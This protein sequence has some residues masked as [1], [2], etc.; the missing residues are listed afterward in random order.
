MGKQSEQIPF[1]PR[2]EPRI[3]KP[4]SLHNLR[5]VFSD[6]VDFIEAPL[7]IG[8]DPNKKAVMLYILGMVRNERANDYILRPLSQNETLHSLPLDEAIFSM[9]KG[10]LYNMS[11]Q[12]RTSTDEVVFDLINGA[13]IL[14]FPER[15]DMLSCMVPTEEKRSV[16]PSNN[17]PALKGSRDSFVES[18]RTNTSLVRRRLRTP[19]LRIKEQ[20]VGRQTI[21]PVDILYIDGLTNPALVRETEKRLKKIDIDALLQSAS[22]EE[23]MCDTVKTPFPLMA[24]T[25][26]PDRF[27]TGLVEG[28]VGILADGLPFG[29]L[30]PGTLGY[31]FKANEDRSKNWL[32][33]SFMRV[34]RYCCMLLALFLPALYV[35]AVNFHPEMLPAAL[36]WSIVEAKL[37]VPFS[38]VFEVLLLLLSFEVVQEAGLRLPPAIGTTVSIL[39]G[40]VVGSAAVEAQIVSPAVLIVVAASGIAG[41]T[42]PSQEF[43][44]A[45][46]LWRVAL[47]IAAAL[48]GL[49]GVVAAAVLLI[50]HLASLESFGVP[51]LTP[52]A[53]TGG[54]AEDGVLRRPL[55]WVKLRERA[56]K[57]NNRRNQK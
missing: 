56:L 30:L 11:V 4:L 55:S 34:L 41:Y 9:C 6:C 14:C 36:A 50:Y 53:A 17:E 10:A 29:Y 5:E 28:R 1:H 43:S 3:S 37:N 38:T 45:L 7:L 51:Y 15:E 52:F 16:G 39:G 31:F 25:E 21:T 46:R 44:G 8:G 26:R 33:V 22:L 47:V 42:M 48:A 2:Q 57:P 49:F 18:I 12:T 24:Y 23:Y 20:L 54:E 32:E 40:L 35:A 19:T 27:C 13:M